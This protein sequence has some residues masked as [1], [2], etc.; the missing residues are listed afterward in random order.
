AETAI[1]AGKEFV[2]SEDRQEFE[3]EIIA[4]SRREEEK[5]TEAFKADAHAVRNLPTD[6]FLKQWHAERDRINAREDIDTAT[7]EA[8]LKKGDA[9]MK[10]LS[11]GQFDPLDTYDPAVYRSLSDQVVSDPQSVKDTD[12]TGANLTPQQKE[13]L[14]DTRKKYLANDVD[15]VTHSTYRRAIQS[16]ITKKAF[17][18][19]QVRNIDL[20]TRALIAY[21][22][23]AKG[24]HTP[25]EYAKFYNDLTSTSINTPWY[26][27]VFRRQKGELRYAVEKNITDLER[28]NLTDVSDDL[29]DVP[30]AEL[31]RRI[32]SE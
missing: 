20:G 2:P 24:E 32:K 5:R 6:D 25:D 10:A 14:L 12:I 26:V 16:L 11:T 18:G 7:K 9:R 21:D 19:N 1:E 31:L 8:E 28:G 23:W 17:S 29:S 22:Q 15:K 3:S 30:D 27:D 13:D 4:V